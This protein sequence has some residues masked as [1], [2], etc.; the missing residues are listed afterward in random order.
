MRACHRP[1]V[2]LLEPKLLFSADLAP[3]PALADASLAQPAL[4]QQATV[5]SASAT[6]EIVFID[7]SVPELETL[8]QDLARQAASGR[9]IEV[10]VIASDEDGLARI[11]QTLADRQDVAAIHLMSHGDDAQVQLGRSVLD[12]Q[13]L[14]QRAGEVAQWGSALAPEGD[15][16]IYGCD[17]AR[18]AEGQALVRNLAAL[19]GADVAA[20]DD[21]TGQQALGGDWT[22]EFSTGA[23]EHGATL[24][25]QAQTGWAHTLALVLLPPSITSNGGGSTATTSVNENTTYVTTVTASSVDSST[26]SL[27][28]LITGGADA[29]RFS[30]D[31]STG[32]LRFRQAP[33]YEAPTDAN[34]DNAYLVTVGVSN[35]VYTT[36]Q[37]LTVNVQDVN[38]APRIVSNGGDGYAI[39]QVTTGSTAITQVQ[40]VDPE[41]KQVIYTISSAMDGA[42]MSIHPSTGVLSFNAP[43]DIA[44]DQSSA[45]NNVYRVFA[46]A[47]DPGGNYSLQWLFIQIVD[48]APVNQTPVIDSDGAAD[49]ASLSVIEGQTAVTTVHA[50]DAESAPL[51]YSLIGGDDQALFDIDASTGAV[52]FKVAPDATAPADADQDNVYEVI[53]GASDGNTSDS[54]ALIIQVLAKNR[55]P[56]NTLPSQFTAQEDT[57]LSLSGLSVHDIDAGSGQITVSLQVQHGTLTVRDDVGGGLSSSQIQYGGAGRQVLLSGTQAQINATLAATN[58]LSYL[59][60][61]DFNGADTLTMVSDDQGHSGLDASGTQASGALTDTDQAILNVT[62]VD[63]APSITLNTLDIAQGGTATP[64]VQISDVDSADSALAL[65]A[66]DISGGHFL[67]TDTQTIVTQFTLDDLRAGRIVFVQDGTAQAPAYTLVAQDGAADSAS[68]AA[69]VTFDA[70]PVITSDGGGASAT[71]NV[72]E[73]STQVTTVQAQDADSGALS[74]AIVGGADQALFTIDSATG[75]LRFGATPDITT[76]PFDAHGLDYTVIVAASDGRSEVRQT[77]NIHLD[78]LNRP[79]VNTVPA[80]ITAQEDTPQAITGLAVSDPD[81]G[82]AAIT[83][84]LQVQHGTL[85]LRDDVAGGLN[86][87]QIQYGGGQRQVLLTGT[88]AQIN[89]TLSAS[90]GVLYLADADYN[91]ADTLGMVSNDLGHSGLGSGGQPTGAPLSDTDQ[92]GITVAAVN[93]APVITLNQ[94]RIEQG[95]RAAPLVQVSD[96]D[97]P[98]SSITLTAQ[99]LRGGRFIDTTSGA[100]VTQFALDDIQAGHIVF[101]QDGSAQA[102]AYTLRVSDGQASTDG[103]ATVDFTPTPPPSPADPLAGAATSPSASDTTA[104]SSSTSTSTGGDTA[105]QAQPAAA[106]LSAATPASQALPPPLPAD[107]LAPA[108]PAPE[109]RADA[110]SGVRVV[111]D[112]PERPN[113]GVQVAPAA[114]MEG[115]Q[116]SWSASLS[117]PGAVEDLR[118][119][120]DA[121]QEQLLG[122]GIERRHVVASSI[123]LST[124]MS[125]GYVIWLIRGGAL[126]GSMLSAMPA[127]QMIDPLPV[128]HRGGG[129]GQA[130]ELGEGDASVEHLFDGD[131]PA[132][133]PPPPPPP[134]PGPHGEP[135]A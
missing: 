65:R 66:Q 121:L 41:G 25:A 13:T 108:L 44:N 126:V 83:V 127:W 95:G 1:V 92:A 106:P 34:G 124:G 63:D 78:T 91:G 69:V 8:R 89:A 116:Y 16:L 62:A 86:A 9:D 135:A 35:G 48:P 54:Q 80:G 88:L 60:D 76:A 24:S 81:A 70:S 93:D 132:P 23:I 6:H 38:E 17:V 122:N 7:A 11:S 131:T 33:N 90:Q 120:L 28:Y 68:S 97:S 29:A 55:P 109:V 112:A 72:P 2:E 57:A 64:I 58:G 129:R 15:L 67:N 45:G 74:Y 133:P 101:V 134:A 100:T 114:E 85:T 20:S 36:T 77:L 119:N 130:I 46:Y 43:V 82:A 110:P 113:V 12:A 49:T 32:E 26:E 59:A 51:T 21:S 19:T 84:S 94:L 102:P 98:A 111:I 22:L 53:V 96:I 128:L 118:R 71:L 14:L 61:A 52:T 123:A 75:V 73:L 99:N 31:A 115:F 18:S 10:I 5:Q 40:A 4:A 39:L 30:I 37:A 105:A 103:N 47:K 117:A 79:P 107:V 104:A 50:S 125:V 56:V 87:S 42:L 3:L 27:S